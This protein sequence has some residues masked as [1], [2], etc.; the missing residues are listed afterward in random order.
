MDTSNT[1]LLPPLKAVTATDQGGI[2][3]IAASLGL[4]FG[5]VS[6][7]MRVYVRVECRAAFGK[8]DMAAV[9]SM[10]VTALQSI[11]VFLAIKRGFG[12]ITSDLTA[13]DIAGWQRDMY[14]SDVFYLVGMWLTKTSIALLVMRLSRDPSHRILARILLVATCL[15]GVISLFVVTLRCDLAHPWVVDGAACATTTYARWA[16]VT[17]LDVLTELALFAGGVWL[18]RDLQLPWSKK[19]VV[20]VAYGLRLPVI[21]A[22]AMRLVYLHRTLLGNGAGRDPSLGGIPAAV[23]TQVELSYAVVAA[24][25]PCLKPFMAALNTQY[26]GGATFVLKQTPPSSALQRSRDDP[27]VLSSKTSKMSKMSSSKTASKA[28]AAAGTMP[29]R[30]S[31]DSVARIVSDKMLDLESNGSLGSIDSTTS[32]SPYNNNINNNNNNNNNNSVGQGAAGMMAD[33]PR[34]AEP[35]SPAAAAAASST[36][37]SVAAATGANKPLTPLAPS[38][39]PQRGG[40]AQS[41]SAV[42]VT[43]DITV[44]QKRAAGRSVLPPTVAAASSH[45]GSGRGRDERSEQI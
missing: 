17:A 12:E 23:C 43:V 21:V 35:T 6:L 37:A 34:A 42:A 28:A 11:I 31:T 36:T 8:D 39:D 19:S 25:L 14:I 33:R 29:S 30:T 24:T 18:V 20:V 40:R 3:A 9:L 4:V 41:P 22:A 26:G 13:G 16:A 1:T 2:L 38:F 32:T 44:S 15:Y 27:G 45:Y 5:I 7:L 10:A